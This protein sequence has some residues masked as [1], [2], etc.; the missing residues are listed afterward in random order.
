MGTGSLLG[1]VLKR[2]RAH[3]R[4]QSL[5]ALGAL[6]AAMLMAAVIIYADAVRDLGLAF[7][8]RQYERDSLDV[9]VYSSSQ[10]IAPADYA[11]REDETARQLRAALGNLAK[12]YIRYGRTATFFLTPPGA[13]V[14]T[15]EN[16]PRAHLQFLEGLETRVRLVAGRQPRVAARSVAEP[17][18]IEAWVSSAAAAQLGL[19]V[20][21]RFDLH[22]YWALEAPPIPVEVVGIFEPLHAND[23]VWRSREERLVVTSTRWPTYPFFVPEATVT[24]ALVAYLPSID[25]TFETIAVVSTE[26]IDSRNALG[27]AERLR[28]LAVNL[29]RAVPRTSVTTELSN[30][31]DLYRTK[32]FFTRLPL[33]ALIAQVVGIVV[34]YLVLVSSLVAD[35]RAEEWALLQS[36]GAS[37]RH[38]LLLAVA[39]A[40]LIA[41]PAAALGPPLAAAGTSLL[42]YAPAFRSLSG[43]HPLE[44]SLSIE[45]WGLAMLGAV[46]AAVAIAAPAV[47][48]GQRSLVQLRH[49]SA[50]PQQRPAFLRYYVDVAVLA[51]AAV[52]FYQLRNEGSLARE[53]LLGGTATDPVLL[54]APSLFMLA[55]ALTVLRLLPLALRALTFLA[56][57]ARGVTLP[58]ALW[59]LV[60]RPLHHS[61]LTLLLMLTTA[62]GVFAA[63]FRAT[64]E[65]S[66]DDRAAYEAAAPARVLGLRS[67]PNRSI[68]SLLQAASSTLSLPADDIMP[69]IRTEASY[70][71]SRFRT[72]DVHLLGLVP[73]LASEFAFWRRD[74]AADSLPSLM[75]SLAAA[76]TEVIPGVPVPAHAQCLGIRAKLP[77]ELPRARLALRLRALDARAWELPAVS[78]GQPDGDG[79][80]LFVVPL[81]LECLGPTYWTGARQHPPDSDHL[82]IDAV[83]LRPGSVLQVPLTV[84]WYIDELLAGQDPPA[85]TGAWFAVVIESF[86][87]LAP[88][89]PVGGVS[90]AVDPGSI[91]A[92][93]PSGAHGRAV[94][95]ST[96]MGPGASP[97]SGVRPRLVAALPLLASA[98]FL[99]KSRLRNGDELE[100]FLNAQV[101]RAHIVGTFELFPPYRPDADLPLLVTD[102]ATLR[103][104]AS[105][106]PA[107]AGVLAPNELWLGLEPQ[108]QAQLGEGSG[109]RADSLLRRSQVRALAESDPLVAASW[110]GILFFSF[111]AVLALTA[112]GFASYAYLAAERRALEFAVLRTVGLSPVQVFTTLLWEHA[113]VIVVGL[114]VGT[115]LGFPLG[116]LMVDYLAF[117]ETGEP[118][119]PPLVATVRWPAV[120]LLYGVIVLV[121]S[122]TM[123][124]LAA[125]YA[126]LALHRTLRLGEA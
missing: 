114:G 26:A 62:V 47:R 2:L 27:L 29:P 106:L 10:R 82:V 12:E 83:Y 126:R 19:A 125:L 100:L 109:L 9:S 72:V 123:M 105:R 25:G 28:A 79:W 117:T 45:A 80:Q 18:F 67:E 98:A 39:E 113:F 89:E 6:C 59:Q 88:Y 110:E 107:L 101:V 42:G 11:L 103:V 85:D 119:V 97:V 63:G 120:A 24:G 77:P 23:R 32:L 54:A 57:F 115:A 84:A 46:V 48:S 20:G 118:I 52:A 5:V 33:F 102:F 60:R 43:G 104:L 108:P 92:A 7:A 8:I 71:L 49:I 17:P 94:L 37:T 21:D 90:S 112:V 99:E 36:R 86:D 55:V 116:R 64:L 68:D 31:I 121:F 53:R 95:V 81:S 38:V 15:D 96:R 111:A 66:Y 87:D 3:A 16:R 4:L 78:L 56:R 34:L 70:S 76:R 58:L 51:I 93:E 61:R 13:A 65:R 30:A 73:E 44:V 69:A 35:R 75:A 91:A 41:L 40:A 1:F 50:R 74:F 14:P 124:A 22:P 122:G